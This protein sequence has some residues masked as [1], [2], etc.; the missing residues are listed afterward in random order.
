MKK[1][2][3]LL[4]GLSLLVSCEDDF[5]ELNT[6]PDIGVPPPE[7]LFTYAEKEMVTYKGGGEWYHENHQKMTWAQYL[8]QGNANDSDINMILPGSKYDAFYLKIMNHLTE[9]R[10]QISEFSPDEQKFYQKLVAA[11][12]V[13]QA[14]FALRITDQFGDIPYSGATD[15]RREGLLDPDYDKQ[16]VILSQLID[17]L[18]NAILKM[19]EDIPETFDFSSND[20]AYQGDITKWIKFANAVKLRIATRLFGQDEG[21][22]R[23]IITSVVSDG[24]LFESNDDQFTIDLGGTY[25][26]AAAAGFEFKGVMWA[27]EPMLDF[28]KAHVDP[29]LRIFYEPNGYTQ[30]T[31]D[32]FETPEAISPAVDIQNDT[33][34]LYTTVDGEEILG[35]RYVGLPTFRN[36]PNVVGSPEYYQ[37]QDQPNSVGVN[38]TMIS[39]YNRR[40]IQ[41]CGYQYDGLPQ[42]EGTYVDVMLSYSEVC[43]MMSEFI[44]KGYTGGDA[45][46]WYLK[47]I[48]SSMET[49]NMLG[50]KQDLTLR[51]GNKE[52]PYLPLSDTEITNYVKNADLQLNGTDDLEKVYLQQ[53][54]NFYRLPEEGWILSMRTGYPKYGSSL[55]ARTPVDSPEIPFPRR[56]PPPEPGDL[57]LE[58]WLQANADQG[59]TSP[60]DESPEALNSQRLW[61][62]Q[63]NPTI[64]SGGN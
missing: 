53:F 25:R 56:I 5:A 6:D 12:E 36:D 64:G 10:L 33:D 62:D 41:N 31:I 61:F 52:Y 4:F 54:F 16:E 45:S 27:P 46:D 23:D 13:L 9:M 24:R 50:E 38:A 18:D 43:F 8:V 37:Y 47:G 57:N 42:P 35:Y 20:L 55:L 44:L 1:L 59:F 17:Q 2:L 49:Y 58:K 63:N 60:R 30:E 29:R 21:Q 19:D 7:T 22:A 14:Y 3:Y 26:G 28:M 51:V 32:T 11:S 34:V 40:L 39:K 48:E 15:G